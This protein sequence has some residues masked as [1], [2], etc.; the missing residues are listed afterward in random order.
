MNAMRLIVPALLALVP[1]T[2]AGNSHYPGNRA[3]LRET[4]FTALPLG[5]VRAQ[6]W[7]LQQLQMQRDGLTG[8]AEEVFPELGETS[9][10]R[11]G[12]QDSWERGPYYVKGLVPLAYTLDDPALKARA[13][14]WVDACLASQ[15]PDGFY[16]PA[17]NDD[18][19][20]RMVSNYSLRD[21]AE[22][23][24]DP[25]VV[26]FLTRY[27]RHMLEHLPQR[28]LRDW[29]KSRAGDEMDTAVWLYNR[30]SDAFLLDLID[31][32]R[33]QAYD[34]PA[35][36]RGNTFQSF[37]PDFQ[38][39]HNVNVPQAMKMP[40][41]AWERS[42]DPDDRAAVEAGLEHLRR[43]HG[44]SFGMESGTEFLSGRSPG[45][46]VEFCSIVERMLSEETLTRILGDARHADRLERVAY[47]GLPAAWN[48]D[49]TALRYYTQPNHVVARRG[50]QGY[51][52]DYDNGI[53]Y[54]PRSGYPCCC[55]N[56]HQGWP[57]LVQNSWAATDDDGLGVIAYA[58]TAVTATVGDGATA[59][60]VED[61]AY[62]FGDEV[63]FRVTVDRP[64]TFPLRLRTPEWCNGATLTVNG[65]AVDAP[66]P[67]SYGTVRRAWRTGDEVVLRLPMAVRVE[68]G[69][70]AS[71]SVHRG[72]LVYAL[73]IEHERRVVSSLAP[74]LDEFEQTPTGAWNYG[75]DLDPDDPAA[76]FE[77]ERIDTPADAN[78]FHA[79]STPVRL[80]ARARHLPTWGLAW[81][82]L[83]AADPPQSPVA[84][85][86]PL[87]AV[88]LVPF[89][90]E[91]LRLT[92]FP[93]L[94]TPRPLSTDALAFDFDDDATTGLS[95]YGGGW[96][97]HDGALRTSPT[98][99]APGFKALVEGVACADV[100][101]EADVTPP[102]AGDAGVVFRVSRPSIGADAYEGYYAG[103][104]ADGR[105]VLGVADGRS[106]TQLGESPHAVPLDRAT[107]LSVTARGPRIEVR[108]DNGTDPVL[109]VDDTRWT[110]GQVGV[111]TYCADGDRAYAMFDNLRVTPLPSEASGAR[112]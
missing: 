80:V 43:E 27:Y 4:P 37:G 64:V 75:L 33:A 60:I 25:R 87:E 88:T 86:E 18:W 45:Q 97:A 44:L 57:K 108:L 34:W 10:W 89:G 95:W 30:T 107:R 6:G 21:Y 13:Q 11:G 39:R 61:T 53:V 8:R 52:Q 7:L 47:N 72:P 36:F 84:S 78:P 12:D 62:P 54:A 67:G 106:W 70:H 5:S 1:P 56:V 22:A 58:P 93:V 112:P 99:G 94:G 85:D 49:L 9:A 98:G 23:T 76:S 40:A 41:V 69:V 104:N 20:P 29:G 65:Q 68:T 14:V 82:A 26:P 31:L 50:R 42:G 48:R 28:P 105:V 59:T 109:V 96:W 77:V 2:L 90:S 35:I 81:N 91:D 66:A 3:P 24:G 51:G 100:R 110:T 79:V 102:P 73:R 46:G 74:G 17:Q 15:R 38:P 71:V 101:I 63:R 32:L 19:W 92:D 55:F 111:R 16:G 103:V 83:V